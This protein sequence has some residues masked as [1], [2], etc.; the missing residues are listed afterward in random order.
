MRH[1]VGAVGLSIRYSSSP[2]RCGRAYS[3][4][5]DIQCNKKTEEEEE[6]NAG[7]GMA[8]GGAINLKSG[9]KTRTTM[10]CSKIR[11]LT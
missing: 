11:A 4:F 1:S 7:Q 3:M 9:A 2:Q 6:E 10:G 5:G 8:R